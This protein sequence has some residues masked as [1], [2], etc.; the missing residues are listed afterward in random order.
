LGRPHRRHARGEGLLQQPHVARD[1]DE[2]VAERHELRALPRIDAD[3]PVRVRR[4]P[5]ES[6]RWQ[7]LVDRLLR[8]AGVD[9]QVAVRPPR[10]LREILARLGIPARQGNVRLPPLPPLWR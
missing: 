1:G 10:E 4:F 5:I 3:K 8:L 7:K 9:A 2:V 6:E